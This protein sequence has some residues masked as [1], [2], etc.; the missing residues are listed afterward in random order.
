[1]TVHMGP[2]QIVVALSLEFR[3]EMT[4]SEIESCVERLEQRLKD[5]HRDISVL[6][7]KPQTHRTWHD[8]QA[9][10]QVEQE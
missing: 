9:Q 7:I 3:D 6:F 4:T 8:R 1:M 2:D 5:Q 10:L